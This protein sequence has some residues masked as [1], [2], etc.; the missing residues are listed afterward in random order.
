[1]RIEEESYLKEVPLLKG[2]TREARLNAFVLQF[3]QDQ[4]NLSQEQKGTIGRRLNEITRQVQLNAHL[5]HVPIDPQELETFVNELRSVLMQVNAPF[6][7]PEYHGTSPLV[8]AGIN[9]LFKGDSTDLSKFPTCDI[10]GALFLGKELAPILSE[11]RNYFQA[12]LNALF[13]NLAE[14]PHTEENFWA[15][16]LIFHLLSYYTFFDPPADSNLEVPL[17]VDGK[18]QKISYDE[19]EKIQ[20]TPSWMGS[21]LVS[22]LLK[23]KDGPPLILFKG[24][25]YPADEGFGLQLLSDLNPGASVGSY[26]F[27]LG[28]KKLQACLTKQVA[29]AGR[30]AI[31][32]GVSLGGALTQ[33]AA[34][35]FPELIEKAF[36]YCAP[37]MLGYELRE[38]NKCFRQNPENLPVVHRFRH[39]KDLVHCAGLAIGE[40][41]QE[42]LLMGNSDSP[43]LV[44]HIE[45][46]FTRKEHL[47]LRVKQHSYSFRERFIAIAHL[48]LSVPLFILGTLLYA[49]MVVAKKI[50]ALAKQLFSH[51]V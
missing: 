45:S 48:I 6:Q 42:Y 7:L 38:W 17:L 23:S 49:L 35:N 46:Y 26:A 19:I 24:T 9:A 47:I 32:V 36:A 2:A 14:L 28:K 50:Y 10:L 34:V 16:G 15:E 31:A 3:F 11:L 39:K 25:S 8:N 13:E 29:L 37:K 44:A 18:W 1:M 33:H 41:W 22:F 21:P 20:L 51:E 5:D 30:K 40:G 27:S 43:A 4:N 12:I